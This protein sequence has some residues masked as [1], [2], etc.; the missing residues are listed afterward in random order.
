VSNSGILSYAPPSAGQVV[1]QPANDRIC[2][3][4]TKVLRVDSTP[5]RA[6][7][8]VGHTERWVISSQPGYHANHAIRHWTGTC[9]EPIYGWAWQVAVD[10]TDTPW[11]T[12][13]DGSIYRWN[14][15]VP[16]PGWEQIA[17]VG[18]GFA[19]T[20]S[21]W[22]GSDAPS[23][24]FVL[25]ADGSVYTADG[26]FLYPSAPG[27]VPLVAIGV[28]DVMRTPWQSIYATD[29]NEVLWFRWDYRP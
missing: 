25:R 15:T 4:A 12:N 3:D 18:S 1:F 22:Q 6:T 16:S 27:G 29:A 11:V 9:W 24:A 13:S 26:R 19:I 14:G 7:V 5:R 2:E 20:E 28:S 17:P 23:S 10:R 8:G 21:T